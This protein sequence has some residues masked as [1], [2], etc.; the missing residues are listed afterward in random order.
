MSVGG[1]SLAEA[2]ELYQLLQNCS[3]QLDEIDDKRVRISR[4]ATRV[5]NILFEMI[6]VLDRMGF[7][8]QTVDQI[9]DSLRKII[10]MVNMLRIALMALQAAT[11]YGMV[12]LSLGL[13][14]GAAAYTAAQGQVRV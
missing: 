4:D 6:T 12:T 3:K 10:Y 14:A 5:L 8:G 13:L 7:G 11:P 9:L 2:R 1:T